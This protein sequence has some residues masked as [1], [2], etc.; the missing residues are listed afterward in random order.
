MTTIYLDHNIIDALDRGKTAYLEPTLT[1][2]EYLLIISLVSV[3][4][5]FRG[6][7]QSRSM[8]NIESLKR[9]GVKYIHSGP[10][11]WHMSISDLDYENMYE[12]WLKMQ[13][14]I[15]PFNNSFFLFI[16]ALFSQSKTEAL[17]DIDRAISDEIDWIKSN[18]DRFQIFKNRWRSS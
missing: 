11:E 4:E 14:D 1:H 16:S 6:G 8:R 2:K 15:G 3:D 17:Q 9:L 7:D 10:N 18:F 5:I 12:K 13:S